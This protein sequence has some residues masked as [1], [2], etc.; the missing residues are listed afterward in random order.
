MPEYE[1]LEQGFQI[2]DWEVFP[3]RGVLRCGEQEEMPEPKV[4]RLL[5][6]LEVRDGDVATKE[7]LV[8]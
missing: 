8:Q 3:A 7:D 5:L 4:L 2:G 1:E 6:S